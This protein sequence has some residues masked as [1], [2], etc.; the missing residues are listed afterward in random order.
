MP[1]IVISGG[2]NTPT[3]VGGKSADPDL[4]ATLL[5]SSSSLSTPLSH[6]HPGLEA[7]SQ[8]GMVLF[9]VSSSSSQYARGE[10]MESCRNV[11]C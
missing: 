7:S 2:L 8:E 10:R 4:M 5:V 1:Y 11:L 9:S 6:F 3:L